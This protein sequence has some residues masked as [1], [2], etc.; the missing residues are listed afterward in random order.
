MQQTSPPT[1]SDF[2]LSSKVQPW[3][4]VAVVVVLHAVL[5]VVLYA[6]WGAKVLHTLP[7]VVSAQLVADA[8]PE[9]PVAPPSEPPPKALVKVQPARQPMSASPVAEVER[10]DAIAPTESPALTAPPAPKTHS[11]AHTTQ[12]DVKPTIEPVLLTAVRVP[13]R[14]QPSGTCSKPEY[15]TI[16][17]RKEEEGTV[18]LKFLIGVQGQVLESLV[19]KSSGFTR[20]DEAARLALAQCQFQPGSVDGQPES[21]WA[22]VK[23]TWQLD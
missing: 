15:P 1:F 12:S 10:S 6:G 4:A 18:L 2:K 19:E 8:V 5:L 7:V 23:Y 3:R 17:R 16:S 21:S 22:Q 9:E 13:A 20:L 11:V 14:L